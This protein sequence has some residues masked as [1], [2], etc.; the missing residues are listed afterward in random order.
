M[1][2]SSKVWAGARTDLSKF[3]LTPR[4]DRRCLGKEKPVF[5]IGEDSEAMTSYTGCYYRKD[6]DKD[7]G[8]SR[9]ACIENGWG[10]P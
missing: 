10:P 2:I 9:K 8:D 1:P 5:E 6:L 3:M 4:E 7:P